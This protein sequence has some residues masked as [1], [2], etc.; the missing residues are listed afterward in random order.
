MPIS[1]TQVANILQGQ[2]GMFSA[3]AQYAQAVS[4]QYGY[5]PSS[6]SPVQD[7][8][9]SSALQGGMAASGGINA[10]SYGAG[11]LGMGAMFNMAP[12]AFDAFTGTA[13][14]ATRGY[15]AAGLAGGIG[16]GVAVGGAYMAAASVF[17]WG[18]DQAA[19]GAQQRGMLNHQ[20]GGMAPGLSTGQV[21][22][23][24]SMVSQAARSGMGSVNELT[25]LMGQGGADGTINMQSL[26]QF[27]SSF[28]KLLG[29]VRSVAV[30]L[31]SSLTEAQMA[32]Q[33]VRNLGV[34]QD[35]AA[36]F[37]GSM[38]GLGQAG[39]V[40]PR[41]MMGMAQ[42]G[43]H[44]GRLTGIGAQAGAMGQM[45]QAG[46]LGM[47]QRGNMIDGIHGGSGGQFQGAAFRFLG[48]RYGRT[49]LA[50][51]MGR[52]GEYD[53]VA[54]SQIAG[55]QLSRDQMREMARQNLS[56]AGA[57][58]RFNARRGE[59]MGRFVSDFGG[60]AI[61]P[62][63]QEMTRG[64]GRPETLRGQLTGLTRA[65]QGA[66]DQLNR[67]MPGLRAKL[68]TEGR[69]AFQRG[70]GGHGLMDALGQN[71]EQ[72]IAP[73]RTA[74]Q[75]YGAELAQSAQG[76]IED[77]TKEFVAKP[78]GR[79]DPSTYAQYFRGH[80]AGGANPITQAVRAG[81][82]GGGANYFGAAGT[83]SMLPSGMQ[84][85]THG[86]GVGPSEL[87]MYGMGPIGHNQWAGAA[88]LGS[89]PF[90]GGRN[91]MGSLGAGI[92]RFGKG[93]MAAFASKGSGFAGLGGVG[94][95]SGTGR[96]AGG[97]ARVGG[98]TLKGLGRLTSA[99]ALPALAADVAF[100]EIPEIQRGLGYRPITQGAILGQGADVL[101]TASDLG[102]LSSPLQSR[103]IGN[104]VG[105]MSYDDMVKEGLT[106]VGG[107]YGEG[108]QL[109]ITQ[110]G[111]SEANDMQ[112]GSGAALAAFGRYGKA[113]AIAMAQAGYSSG[114]RRS[115]A[116][117]LS[118]QLGIPLEEAGR[119]ITAASAQGLQASWDNMSP[120]EYRKGW[121]Q[122]QRSAHAGTAGGKT[123][124]RAL[125]HIGLGLAIEGRDAKNADRLG[126]K[127]LDA[128]QEEWKERG[129][130]S[131]SPEYRT[132]LAGKLKILAKGSTLYDYN[133]MAKLVAAGPGGYDG[134]TLD[135]PINQQ[136][137]NNWMKTREVVN[138]RLTRDKASARQGMWSAATIGG[139]NS[140]RAG[141]YVDEYAKGMTA[142][143]EDARVG[144]AEN[145]MRDMLAD[146]SVTARGAGMMSARLAEGDTEY[147]GRASLYAGEASRLKGD[148]ER[149][150]SGAQI[151]KN[152]L[153]A[154]FSSNT[155]ARMQKE[156]RDGA[157]W[158]A[159]IEANLVDATRKLYK[160]SAG[161][162]PINH[163]EVEALSR[164]IHEAGKAFA[165]GDKQ[166]FDE[167][168]IK[169]ATMEAKAPSGAGGNIGDFTK[170]MTEVVGQM[171]MFSGALDTINRSPIFQTLRAWAD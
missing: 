123:Y 166:A 163:N 141:Q 15:G 158:T 53:S 94:W 136:H 110:E 26:G 102:Q 117:V 98:T 39:G 38:K 64:S 91:A 93:M 170:Q 104:M 87:P 100:N 42:Q 24:S 14:A 83:N 52:D 119:Y 133:D 44:L 160:L 135:D 131:S 74:L 13:H 125:G 128:L 107:M 82:G 28:Q 103:Q 17:K 10:A 120:E 54:A 73:Y 30:A 5:Q 12:R 29:N 21:G 145:L 85:V 92:D 118:N 65:D 16:A 106:P 97:I 7:P 153:G 152:L 149:G 113:G 124:N 36:G 155:V 23:M 71:M 41:E 165:A 57:H 114:D 18:V 34:G 78:P 146:P 164:Q 99:L 156:F 20:I 8:R 59:L 47:V 58:D 22:Q 27:Q 46:A 90:S 167:V 19:F 63:L 68:S 111:L 159:G 127:T 48:S 105:G 45:V 72:I 161:D 121:V 79:A 3:A 122:R 56:G 137:R 108:R 25:S 112:R 150:R 143:G 96:L 81:S 40:G 86:T 77:V 61:S 32:M 109:T 60:Q 31:K 84:I 148:I 49:P 126:G 69:A 62:A 89:I 70:A 95:G 168:G 154:N 139:F 130:T 67:A 144:A 162:N 115:Q 101:R 1:S 88:A 35:Q 50:A 11:A 151:V 6:A 33:E 116:A 129:M 55:G 43:A 142:D 171:K 134:A 80:L 9:D 66:M 132:R 169:I 138:P 157:H 37:L 76:V 147:E 4:A 2:V 51:M 75:R 140:A